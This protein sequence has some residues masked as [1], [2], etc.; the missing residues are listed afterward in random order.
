MEKN[1]FLTFTRHSL[2]NNRKQFD[3]PY[4]VC[5]RMDTRNIR[6]YI[7]MNQS[8]QDNPSISKLACKIIH[9]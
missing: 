7:T 5:T 6:T 2:N 4:S 9:L 8:N 3:R 1:H